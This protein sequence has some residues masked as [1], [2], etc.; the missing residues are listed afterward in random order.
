MPNLIVTM[1]GFSTTR[2]DRQ[3]S[4]AQVL[5]VLPVFVGRDQDIETS[6]FSLGNQGRV[7]QPSS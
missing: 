6:S 7:L 1:S 4:L 3:T 5:L 2:H